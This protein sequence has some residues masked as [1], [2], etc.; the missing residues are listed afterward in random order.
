MDLDVVNPR[1][2]ELEVAKE[3]LDEL[4]DIRCHELDEM[5]R[6]RMEESGYSIR[7]RLMNNPKYFP[8]QHYIERMDNFT[9]QYLPSVHAIPGIC[10]RAV[11]HSFAVG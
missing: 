4:F 10:F 7:G 8:R 2:L 6:Q 9:L 11:V 1:M 5:I 3:I